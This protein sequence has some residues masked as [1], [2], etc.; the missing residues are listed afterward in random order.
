MLDLLPL[1]LMLD[2]FFAGVRCQAAKSYNANASATP[3]KQQL[4]QKHKYRRLNSTAT[5]TAGVK[6]HPA[7]AGNVSKDSQ[8]LNSQ[9]LDPSRVNSS[10]LDPSRVDPLLVDSS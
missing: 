10:H 7:S 6:N 5:A 2:C 3:Y 1:S 9:A 4:H 8:V